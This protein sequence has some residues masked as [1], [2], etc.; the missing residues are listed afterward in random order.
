MNSADESRQGRQRAQRLRWVGITLASYAVD[1]LFLSLFVL[2]G[3]I[4]AGVPL[5]YGLAAV[6]ISAASYLYYSSAWCRRFAESSSSTAEMFVAMLLQSMVVWLAPQIAFPYLANLLTVL[7][8]GALQLTLRQFALVW[9]VGA[10]GAGLALAAHGAEL[11]IPTASRFELLLVWLY[12]A[13]VLGRCVYL[14]VAAQALRLKLQDSRQR[15]AAALDQVQQ[16]AIRDELTGAFNRRYMMG[17]LR[18]EGAR[19]ERTGQTF[20]VALFDLDHFKAVND[21]HGHGAGDAVLKDFARIAGE[22]I[23]ATDLFGRYGGEEFLLLMPATPRAQAV[24]AVER[25][26]AGMRDADWAAIAAGLNVTASVGVAESHG[27]HTAEALLHEADL[28]L[29]EAK[30]SG[31]NRAVA[32]DGANRPHPS[33]PE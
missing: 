12:F 5:A 6:L 15:L 24:Q 28:A 31:R 23:R 1:T 18:E 27:E 13:T 14:S 9:A 4:G 25:I 30:R 16:I 19:F 2:A 22:S 10:A 26:R 8:F 7:S 3:T 11:G 29:Y 32:A 21:T 17:R 33:I 20:S